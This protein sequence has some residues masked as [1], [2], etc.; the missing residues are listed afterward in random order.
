MS[1]SAARHRA[2]EKY[3]AKAYDEIKLRVAKGMKEEIKQ[4]AESMNESVNAFIKRAIENQIKL[5]NESK[6]E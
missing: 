2:N 6:N 5:D 1:I 3:N 4:H